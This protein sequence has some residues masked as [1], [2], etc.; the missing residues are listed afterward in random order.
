[1]IEWDRQRKLL[2]LHAAVMAVV[3]L[4]PAPKARPMFGMGL[5]PDLSADALRSLLVAFIV[6]VMSPILI[7]VLMVSI[8]QT[9]LLH[10]AFV[11]LML[12][13]LV[14]ISVVGVWL[15]LM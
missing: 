10:N 9:S 15:T 2:L 5:I 8:K 4:F 7:V 14:S 1:M 13:A 6:A 12:S 11:F 3:F